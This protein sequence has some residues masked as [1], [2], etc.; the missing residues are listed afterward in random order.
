MAGVTLA[1]MGSS[2]PHRITKPV[3]RILN[4]S[5]RMRQIVSPSKLSWK[6][7]YIEGRVHVSLNPSVSFM[8]DGGA[9]EVAG[10]QGYV[11][12]RV[13]T[14]NVGG[15]V[16]LSDNVLAAGSGGEE[17]GIDVMQTEMSVLVKTVL[18][19][20]NFAWSRDGSGILA[21]ISSSN[22]SAAE[23]NTTATAGQRYVYVTDIRGLMVGGVYEVRDANSSYALL[24]Y[25]TVLKRGNAL[26]SLGNPYVYVDATGLPTGVASGDV[27]VKRG[28]YGIALAGLEKLVDNTAGTFQYVTIGGTSGYHEYVSP[29]MSL[30]SGSLDA[31]AFRQLLAGIKQNLD[32][33]GATNPTL[34]WITNNWQLIEVEELY[35]PELRV[36]PGQTPGLPAALE[37]SFGRVEPVSDPDFP[38]GEHICIDPSRIFLA[39]QSELHWRAV[40]G[41]ELVPSQQAAVSNGT[42]WMS[43]NMYI[44]E[45]QMCGKITSVSETKKFPY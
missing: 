31:T 11:P 35:E 37:T 38:Y 7:T 21:T 8:Q 30:S 41:Q 32:S 39:Q 3:I 42:V 5:G 43:E 20:E 1:N 12:F 22:T 33:D 29:C 9:F 40:G 10:A 4:L 27:L 25:V 45:R 36:S 26:G 24:G 16:Q 14:T 13:Y 15:S 6:G 2:F 19:T 34:K 23:V 17:N 44:T 18:K 28:T